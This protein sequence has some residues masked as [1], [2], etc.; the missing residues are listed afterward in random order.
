MFVGDNSDRSE[1]DIIIVSYLYVRYQIT[2]I[3]R[4]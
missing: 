3:D 2:T 4:K 1:A